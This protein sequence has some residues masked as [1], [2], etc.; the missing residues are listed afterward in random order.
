MTALVCV[1]GFMGG[2]AQWQG[3]A[4]LAEGRTLVCVDLPGFGA[5]A[6]LAP[7]KRLSDFADWV[8]AELTSKGIERFDLLGHSMGGMIVQEIIHRAP[9][10]VARLILYGTGPT[11]LLPERFETFETS[12]DRARTDGAEAT[13]RRISATWFLEGDKA[14]AYPACAEIAVASTLP[15]IIA[16]LEAM[17]GWRGIDLKAIKAD[18]L[19][20]WG[21]RDRTYAWPQ[22]ETLWQ[23]IDKA[24][25][26][27]VPGT[28]HAVHMEEPALFNQLLQ[29]FL[30]GK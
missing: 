7:I 23:T 9:E 6:H 13:A 16:G 4:P 19:V 18:T 27:V 26:A 11:G 20:I 3:Q 30:I 15:A 25:L 28:A 1:H 5:N 24:Q 17:R 8:L 22:I 14:P 10:R 21:D 29:R 2:G 12:M